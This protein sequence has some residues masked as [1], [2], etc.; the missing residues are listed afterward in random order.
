MGV[1]V[2]DIKPTLAEILEVGVPIGSMA[3]GVPTATSDYDV[4]MTADA[5]YKLFKHSISQCLDAMDSAAYNAIQPRNGY[6]KIRY[7]FKTADNHFCDILVL[8]YDSDLAIIEFAM[9][10]LAAI[11]KYLMKDKPFRIAAFQNALLH[12]G[13]IAQP[14]VEKQSPNV[15]ELKI[16]PIK[17]ASI[18]HIKHI[19]SIH[20]CIPVNIVGIALYSYFGRPVTTEDIGHKSTT[21]D[22]FV[23][24]PV[25]RFLS[26]A[27]DLTKFI[28]KNKADL[29]SQEQY[30]QLFQE[31]H[32]VMDNELV[33]VLLAEQE[34]D[35]TETP[36]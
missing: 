21:R 6:C 29:L 34:E 35:F 5:Y 4:Y 8:E 32:K 18:N 26:T 3:L 17:P 9:N 1:Q 22:S 20:Y 13:F 16:Y 19:N 24:N 23:V 36:F 33:P 30:E 14:N 27:I 11:P 10:D 25:S 2:F 12:Y 7:K 31:S 28:D 15:Y